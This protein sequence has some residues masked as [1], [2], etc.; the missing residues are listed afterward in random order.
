MKKKQEKEVF[1]YEVQKFTIPER[2]MKRY[3]TENCIRVIFNEEGLEKLKKKYRKVNGL[4]A[5]LHNT[6][7]G[8]PTDKR[9]LFINE[10]LFAWTSDLSAIIIPN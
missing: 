7:R 10:K 9:S 8:R 6:F 1:S 2:I 5:F 4:P 3:N